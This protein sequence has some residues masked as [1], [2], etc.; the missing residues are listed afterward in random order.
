[1]RQVR[2]DRTAVELRRLALNGRELQEQ[3]GVP[4]AETG[5][6]LLYLQEQVWRDPACNRRETLLA[7]AR[8]YLSKGE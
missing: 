5:K 3:V 4:P 6:L 8:Q 7:L 1:M 2:R